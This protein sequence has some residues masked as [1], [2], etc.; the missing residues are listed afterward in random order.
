MDDENTHR[1]H[2]H[3]VT[4]LALL[5]GEQNAN[6]KGF[7]QSKPSA[8]QKSLFDKR[9]RGRISPATATPTQFP[10]KSCGFPG[11]ETAR[12]IFL[13]WEIGFPDAKISTRPPH[14]SLGAIEVER[15]ASPLELSEGFLT[16]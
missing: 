3:A 16:V 5:M 13:L 12:K 11:V 15:A 14:M 8:C 2:G 6:K 10:L 7:E 9:G 4:A 1:M